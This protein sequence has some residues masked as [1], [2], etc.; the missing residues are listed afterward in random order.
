[1]NSSFN[2]EEPWQK[3]CALKGR[4]KKAPPKELNELISYPKGHPI[5]P[6]KIADLQ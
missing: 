6:N 1:M 4:G 3:V 2:I 5:N